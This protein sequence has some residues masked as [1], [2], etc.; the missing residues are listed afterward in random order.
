[1]IIIRI[2]L[3]SL[4]KLTNNLMKQIS[5]KHINYTVLDSSENR[6]RLSQVLGRSTVVRDTAHDGENTL[7]C[8]EE[9]GHR[10]GVACTYGLRR[11]V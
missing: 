7:L 6:Y 10:T 2:T 8:D 1:M 11:R 4:L 9:S 5:Y 3:R